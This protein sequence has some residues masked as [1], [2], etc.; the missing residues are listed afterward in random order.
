MTYDA[1]AHVWIGTP[2]APEVVV[3]Y[4]YYDGGFASYITNE[5]PAYNDPDM[6]VREAFDNLKAH[7]VELQVVGSG[8]DRVVIAAGPFAAEQVLSER[9]VL[10]IHDRLE[11]AEVVVSI[12]RRDALLACPA[13]A[14]EQLRRTVTSLHREA[15]EGRSQPGDQVLD[16]LV[17]F[18]AG[19]KVD[20]IPLGERA[21]TA[22]GAPLRWGAWSA[23]Q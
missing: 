22:V 16:G 12:P 14:S 10:A 4:G 1:R 9:H 7:D 3:A 20:K 17:V 13:D 23:V 21:A 6:L 8:P 15:W 18:S 5:T 19:L 11:A 2:Q